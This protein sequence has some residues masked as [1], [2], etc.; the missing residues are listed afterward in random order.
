MCNCSSHV[1]F[2]STAMNLNALSNS[3][4]ESV[5]YCMKN[6]YVFSSLR[7]IYGTDDLQNALHGSASV[8]SAEQEIRFFFPDSK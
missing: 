2:H 8:S 5:V 4:H 1:C 6:E 7:A 3:F